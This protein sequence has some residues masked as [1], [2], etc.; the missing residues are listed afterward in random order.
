MNYI[1]KLKD[2]ADYY[3]LSERGGRISWES[4]T[5]LIQTSET[6][7]APFQPKEIQTIY[8]RREVP[9]SFSALKNSTGVYA[10]EESIQK[11]WATDTY[12]RRVENVEKIPEWKSGI[13]YRR[14]EDHYFDLVQNGVK[15][16]KELLKTDTLDVK[17]KENDNTY[18]IGDSILAREK[19]T[20]LVLTTKITKKI[21]TVDNGILNIRYEVS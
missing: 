1:I 5:Y 17:L 8:Y 18:Y 16:L 7:P 10:K 4:N 11:T 9:P 6:F 14:T 3:L 13:Y 21:V 2:I 15:K 19:V 20:G 12:Y